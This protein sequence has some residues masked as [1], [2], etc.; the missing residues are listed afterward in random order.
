MVKKL[1]HAER[2]FW[3]MLLSLVTFWRGHAQASIDI[4][5]G[6]L[7]DKMCCE[8]AHYYW[9]NGNCYTTVS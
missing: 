7:S 6:Q 8:N 2:Y 4:C 3:L 5:C 9:D 1:R